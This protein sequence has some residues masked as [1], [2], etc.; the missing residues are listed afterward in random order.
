MSEDLLKK[1]PLDLSELIEGS[2][3]HFANE[4][5]INGEVE[6]PESFKDMV[7]GILEQFFDLKYVGKPILRKKPTENTGRYDSSYIHSD[8]WS[9]NS[10]GKIIMFPICGDFEAGGVEFFRPTKNLDILN[11]EYNDYRDVPDFGPEYIGKMEEGYMH[12]V[13]TSCLHRTMKGGTRYSVD[14][15]LADRLMQNFLKPRYQNYRLWEGRN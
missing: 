4:A 2:K 15:R 10:P 13:S 3:K 12:I 11:V 5:R 14:I 8:V 7:F 9:G 6:T 1:V